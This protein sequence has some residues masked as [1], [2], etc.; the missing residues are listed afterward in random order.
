[1]YKS[2]LDGKASQVS[3]VILY[4]YQLPDMPDMP[5]IGLFPIALLK[6]SLFTERPDL[7]CVRLC[8]D[9]AV[10]SYLTTRLIGTVQNLLDMKA[11][12]TTARCPYGQWR[13]SHTLGPETVVRTQCKQ[14]S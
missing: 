3:I 14:F 10:F 4:C 13:S 1:M 8:E 11:G 9:I 6:R 12:Q 2:H 5:D 7:C